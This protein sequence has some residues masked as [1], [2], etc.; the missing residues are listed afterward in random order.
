MYQ[1][2]I[3]FFC[4]FLFAFSINAQIE[5]TGT[6]MEE[7][8]EY[9]LIGVTVYE[10]NPENG[11]L[12]GN[13]GLVAGTV[14]DLDGKF[15]IF[16]KDENSV[17]VFSYIGF[18]TQEVAVNDQTTLNVIMSED[19]ARLDEVVVVGYGTQKKREV[20][21]AIT[22]I[23]ADDLDDMPVARIEQSL[24]GRTSGVRVTS[25]SGAPGE[26]ATVRIRGTTSLTNGSEPLYVVDGVIVGGGIDFLNQGDIE[27]IEVLKDAAS[28]SIY[29]TRSAAGVILV[30][31]K[32]GSKGKMQVNYNGYIGTQAPWKKLSLLNATEYGILMNESSVASGGEVLFE[33]PE[34]LGEGTDWQ[35]AIFNN[36]A[37]I[38]NHEIS[39]SA[40]SELSQYYAS[41]GYFDQD[42]IIS[43]D[44]S[45]YERFTARFNST[46]KINKRLTFG[47]TL[48]YA[49]ITSQGV[50]TNSEFGSPV[51]RAVN[52]DPIT[53]ILETDPEELNTSTYTD[54]AV[55]KNEEGFPYGISDYV[56]SEVLNPVAALSIQQGY[57]WSDKI[58][59][60]VFGELE[61]IEGLKLRSSIGGDLSFWG[62]EGF[63]PVHYLNSSNRIDINSYSRGQNRGLS[64]IWD[65][66]LSYSRQVDEHNFTVM[67]GTS[68]TQN[69]G[70]GIGG[71]VQNIPVDNIDDASLLF[72][73][74]AES[75]TYGGFEY[76]ERLASYLGRFTYNY[77]QKY[78]LSLIMRID[79]STKFGRNYKFGQF[80]SVSAG[81]VL[82]EENF[83]S[84]H[85][86]INFLKLRGSWGVNGNDQIGDN[87]FVSTIGGGRN[88][89]FGLDNQLINGVSPNAIA[90]PDLRWERTTQTNIGFDAKIF[91][92]VSVTF[93]L[94]DKTTSGMLLDI[95]VPD[96]V[97]NEGPI[98]NLSSMSNKGVELELGYN[99]KFNQVNFDISGN[100]SYVENEVTDL[101][102][103]KEFLLGQTF[104]PQGLEIT[105]TA[106]GEPIG[107]LYGFKTNGIFQTED[108]VKAHS[109]PEG[110]LLQPDA[111][112]GDFRFV[113]LNKD[114]VLDAD[115]RTRIG[116]PTPN[117][118]Y[119]INLGADWKGIDITF[120]GQGVAGNQIFKATRRFDLQRANLTSDALGR[121]T[122][123]NTTDKYPRLVRD[124]PNQNFSRSSDFYVEDGSFFR[125]KTLQV[126]YS[127][128]NS[129]VNFANL[130]KIR[131][132]VSAN[133][134]LTFTKYTGFDPEIGGG[135]FGVDRGI[136]QQPRFFLVG[137]NATF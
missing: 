39:M 124:D 35:D 106:V 102:E 92:R 91:K 93:D 30:T 105:R 43:Q 56:T 118:T 85:S 54:F 86:T 17:L 27:S 107:Y 33:N 68:I 117:W 51:S 127:L 2:I 97:G 126:G 12:E 80:P 79:G 38:Q 116:D 87:L 125:I 72:F 69:K 15:S 58:V 131:V 78:L 90:N 10:K 64:W 110:E 111:A 114:G 59:G 119:G 22:K 104:G 32:K 135:S 113:D 123:E 13:S 129:I 81:W 99:N 8:G 46:H 44:Q 28:A 52:L 133:N 53:P 132:Y 41:F 67:V 120:F 3:L 40:G 121:W 66:T 70:Q 75:Q 48:A 94:F 45:K 98:G 47:N 71:S 115:D 29:G 122:G 9:P 73:T 21:G 100:L 88:Y 57:G 137:I 14:T 26:G 134:L 31:T 101:G 34:S 25:N 4:C 19:V 42:G 109:S 60:C 89:T 74:T 23:S 37:L 24:Q 62:N 5:I 84:K 7:G 1:R 103:E 82:T 6:V 55:V 136:Y 16:V 49:R 50:S 63:T 108:E 65:N 83:L 77:N 95:R 96:Y 76:L 128:T 130:Q 18:A 61:L 20:T 11:N 112:P 36:N